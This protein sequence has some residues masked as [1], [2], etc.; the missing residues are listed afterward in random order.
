VIGYAQSTFADVRGTTRDPA[1]L[2]LP[3]T[4]VTLRN[5]DENTARSVLSDDNANF[6]F[7]NLKPGHYTLVSSKEG[8]ATSPITAVELEARQSARVDL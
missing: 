7:E 1:G 3:Q 8:F 4:L 6:L 5:V 2:A